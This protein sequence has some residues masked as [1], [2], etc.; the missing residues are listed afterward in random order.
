MN[1]NYDNERNELEHELHT[2]IIP[3]TEI[4]TDVGTHH[5]V[6]SSSHPDRVLVPQP[7][8]D[9]HDPLNW[10]RMRKLVVMAS[11]T[12]M[13][14]SQGFG[15][16]ALA[17]MFPQLME[18]FDASL[19]D[20]VKFTGVCILVLGFSNFFWIPIQTTFGRR[21]VLIFST[22]IFVVSNIWRATA[23]DYGSYMGACVLNGFGAGPAETSQPEIIADIL[24]LHERGAYNTLYFTFYFGSLM[25]G[26]IVSGPMAE[27]V[28]WRNFFWLNVGL[29][30]LALL[31]VV[32]CFPET[33]WSR[34]TPIDGSDAALQSSDTTSDPEKPGESTFH[35]NV[36]GET[37]NTTPVSHVGKGTPS[38]QQFKLW[39]PPSN[40]FKTLLTS[41]WIPWKLHIFPIV[42]LAAFNV[43]WSASVFLTLNLTQ[44]QAFAAPPYNF[45]SETIGFFNIAILIGAIIGL[46]TNGPLSDWISMRAT[47]KNGGIR[48]PEMRLPAVIPYLI[49]SIIGNFIVAF[50]Y[51]YKWDWRAIVIIGYTAAG[52]QVAALPAIISTYAVDS[53]KPAAGSIFVTITVNKNLWG[54]GFSEFITT[55]I[56][57]D[58]FVK[59]IML[60]MSL[61]V[62]W[63]LCCIPFYVYGKRL[64]RFT[65]KSKVHSM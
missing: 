65:A 47:I 11:V 35:E 43:S 9:P 56:E 41:F 20:V 64:R 44:S 40:G 22:L 51:Q 33:K 3:G 61:A 26:P 46:L 29:L 59:P 16:L 12:T 42:E 27:R 38:K 57:K 8:N 17:P 39:Q 24:F 31:L 4:M 36:T 6:K 30:G 34:I 50:G 21:P 14:F 53:Y 63:C 62:L 60:N 55:W 13:T 7:S 1:S 52:I 49:V 45:S 23:K 28:G 58:G 32:F 5:F 25:V 19:A 2:E 15:P 18:A 48:E 10:S 37:D 54:Y